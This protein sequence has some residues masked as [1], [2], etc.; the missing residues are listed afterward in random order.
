[1]VD[2]SSLVAIDASVDVT[3]CVEFTN[4]FPF[5]ETRGQRRIREPASLL[6][7]LEM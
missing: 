1:M 7:S 2:V 4:A 3:V 5:T 6:E